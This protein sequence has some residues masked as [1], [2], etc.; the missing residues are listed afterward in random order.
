MTRKIFQIVF[1]LFM[2]LAFGIVFLYYIRHT[3]SNPNKYKEYINSYPQQLHSI[4]NPITI[5]FTEPFNSDKYQ[6]NKPIDDK[7]IKT[8]P[9]IKGTIFWSD[10]KTLEFY[11]TTPLDHNA[12]YFVQVNINDIITSD[13]RIKPFRFKLKTIKQN[14]YLHINEL[15]FNKTKPTHRILK[16]SVVFAD[17]VNF[18][19]LNDIFSIKQKNTLLQTEWTPSKQNNSFWFTI[20]GIE[21]KDFT[22]TLSI[23][24][25]IKQK[26]THI[27]GEE[28]VLIPT[29]N[30]FKV[31]HSNFTEA[32]NSCIEI[33][34]SGLIKPK[35]KFNKLISLKGS[36]IQQISVQKNKIL[37]KLEK[38]VANYIFL[39]INKNLTNIY[40]DKLTDNYSIKIKKPNN[41]PLLQ[42]AD[43]NILIPNAHN[44]FAW[45]F[46]A[47][48]LDAVNVKIYQIFENNIL[49]F[50][51]INNIK[52][53]RQL[54]RVGKLVYNKQIELNKFLYFNK[55]KLTKYTLNIS[56]I[57]PK[58]GAIYSI[59]ATSD[60][61][62]EI[63]QNLYYTKQNIITKVTAGNKLYIWVVDLIN[64]KPI[65]NAKVELLNYQQ[66]IVDK[67]KTDKNGLAIFTISN[68]PIFVKASS[69]LGTT[70]LKLSDNINFI[71]DF[72]SKNQLL[73]G[74]FIKNR[75]Y[76]NKGDTAHICFIHNNITKA[77]KERL[78][79]YS[80]SK[81]NI[82]TE[83]K[84][85]KHS[86]SSL[87]SL[88][89]PK[90]LETGTYTAEIKI[91]QHIFTEQFE[92]V[93]QQA[94]QLNVELLENKE[95]K[96]FHNYKFSTNFIG[97]I[98]DYKCKATIVTHKTRP[99]NLADTNSYYFGATTQP[100]DTL[101]L[102]FTPY[103]KNTFLIQIPK[104]H[105][106]KL[107]DI[108][109]E[110]K[111]ILSNDNIG[112]KQVYVN[113]T[114][115]HKNPLW[116]IKLNTEYNNLNNY[117]NLNIGIKNN[118]KKK[119]K[120]RTR[121]KLQ[122]LQNINNK[123]IKISDKNLAIKGNT[124]KLKWEVP[125]IKQGKYLLQLQTLKGKLLSELEF[126]ITNNKQGI[127]KK[128][129]IT[130]SQNKLITVGDTVNLAV[131]QKKQHT[132]LAL[133]E[134][135]KGIF[136]KKWFTP[137]QAV[138]D[139]IKFIA[140]PSSNNI[141]TA[142]F[143][144]FN[145]KG[146]TSL[147]V[148]YLHLKNITTPI[149]PLIFGKE[150]INTDNSLNL[151]VKEKYKQPL[152][153]LLLPFSSVDLFAE[154]ISRFE[155][156][157][158]KQNAYD[159]YLTDL[160][161]I[162]NCNNVNNA[163]IVSPFKKPKTIIQSSNILDFTPKIFKLKSQESNTHNIN[164]PAY[165]GNAIIGLFASSN[166]D[167]TY[168]YHSFLVDKPFM[169]FVTSPKYL[170]PNEQVTLPINIH[171]SLSNTNPLH[172]NINTNNEFSVVGN[173]DKTI[174]NN[175]KQNTDTYFTIQ[176]KNR[177][178]VGEFTVKLADT[179]YV[180]KTTTH[181]PIIANG[182]CQQSFTHK[183]I[184]SGEKW[185]TIFL[186][187]GIKGTNKVYLEYSEYPNLN[188]TN[189]LNQLLQNKQPD[190]EHLVSSAFALM[191]AK[192]ILNTN[193]VDDYDTYIQNTL[194]ALI[195]YQNADGGF[196]F[197]KDI[198]HQYE[199]LNSYVGYFMIEAE[200][201]GFLVNKAMYNKWLRYHKKQYLIQH[202]N[203]NT[204]DF[205]RTLGLFVLTL[206][207]NYNQDI[208]DRIKVNNLDNT[209]TSL[210]AQTY[211]NIDECNQAKLLLKLYEEKQTNKNDS[212]LSKLTSLAIQLKT[213]SQT[214]NAAY[215]D[216]LFTILSK[217]FN[218]N[219]TISLQE[220]TFSILAFK[221]FFKG[222][223]NTTRL[224]YS[225]NNSTI[226]KHETNKPYG[227][228]TIPLEFSLTQKLETTNTNKFSINIGLTN[229]G[230][231]QNKKITKINNSNLITA[232]IKLLN[233]NN[234]EITNKDIPYNDVITTQITIKP[235]NKVE[236]KNML[237]EFKLPNCATPLNIHKQTYNTNISYIHQDDNTI[238]Y[239]FT[240]P[241]EGLTINIP[242]FID[243]K[244]K[245]IY[246]PIHIY[247]LYTN[248]IEYYFS[249]YFFT[250][251]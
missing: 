207:N 202:S 161:G 187:E 250:V 33:N 131:P 41:K 6:I 19:N 54:S 32:N 194:N 153:Y 139:S 48:K 150:E 68:N 58:E 222:Y 138:H 196:N 135:N 24:W 13:E 137:S 140:P 175:K 226:I 238:Y 251:N 72:V 159:T 108:K 51:Q 89:I 7:L 71:Q 27:V 134:N 86:K 167:F 97:N 164:I 181:I 67:E 39:K 94:K 185:Q 80:P 193:N 180:A 184:K 148:D 40:G 120:K 182:F 112:F 245:F 43:T 233:H 53:N 227:S 2:I 50:L 209:S 36:K 84:T 178:S 191:E 211:C 224:Q 223:S 105:N 55:D 177:T 46:K 92:V 162:K 157:L 87:Y 1:L 100:T 239:Y 143:Y 114:I 77:T 109:H 201:D 95:T 61:T 82:Y 190:I 64:K 103:T 198:N 203:S 91:G 60:D 29:K 171:K 170:S 127:N 119:T 63:K 212:A 70:F 204:P 102:T 151:I 216:S 208:I 195:H 235:T 115:P 154:T 56:E 44:N 104:K 110:I 247:N 66:Q 81:K 160:S 73:K 17:F 132:V 11:P 136:Y 141:L 122:L 168:A 15:Q 215:A 123:Y 37:L 145:D 74:L 65:K 188:L 14:L 121:L 228:I 192:H 126:N 18:N 130:P 28:K 155:N 9:K 230:N 106:D 147:S 101:N 116:G 88:Y 249:S 25:N 16:G 221:E 225:L 243:F 236:Y 85:K 169:F 42:L 248:D 213:Y 219:K 220:L 183:T 22:D 12:E 45:H 142:T 241:A 176:A 99:S 90:Y 49:Q 98:A 144:Y 38:E 93:P 107:L 8:Y 172:L 173:M 111:I 214:K 232:N 52:T 149:K 78:T 57:E 47:K 75:K 197:W 62:K 174:R 128:I 31:R 113:N 21:S 118:K 163:P 186:P 156:N 133:V 218:T 229:I 117:L 244:G 152:S 59:V 242:Q 35:Q 206:A 210:L 179:L 199:W 200:K 26:N 3:E 166:N 246:P 96:Q 189:R 129:D 5:E 158:H 10:N 83:T 79:I 76:Y 125:F 30:S 240:L 124:K 23:T 231:K 20:K 234:E 4:V 165:S 217:E 237:M 69:N 205:N 146:E 34:M